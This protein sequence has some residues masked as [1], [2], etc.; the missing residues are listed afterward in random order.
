MQGV[1]D[2]VRQI[3]ER[4]D[5]RRGRNGFKA[6][7][8]CKDSSHLRADIRHSEKQKPAAVSRHAIRLQARLQA[9]RVDRIDSLGGGVMG[10]DSETGLPLPAGVA[11]GAVKVDTQI[12]GVG[13]GQVCRH[14]Q[15]AALTP[16]VYG[17][18]ERVGRISRAPRLSAKAEEASVVRGFPALVADPEFAADIGVEVPVEAERNAVA[19]VF[20]QDV[21]SGLG[22]RPPVGDAEL[23]NVV[24]SGILVEA[25]R[26]HGVGFGHRPGLV[27]RRQPV[28]FRLSDQVAVQAIDDG[29]SHAFLRAAE[30]GVELRSGEL[31]S[32]E[33]GDV[34][35]R[36]VEAGVIGM[37]VARP[38]P[39]ATGVEAA[40][41]RATPLVVAAVVGRVVVEIQFGA[42]VIPAGDDVDHPVHGR[43]A[44]KQY[45]DA[46]H[47]RQWNG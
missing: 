24:K 43:G 28:V 21:I 12:Q 11:D 38:D 1:D 33:Q 44:V 6:D 46:F 13:V 30:A 9:L 42:L 32:L 47:E 5:R 40:R 41:N 35:V 16:Y 45:L 20:R 29:E 39:G 8:E 15:I 10:G 14:R 26:Q 4:I 31:R 23:G 18:V 19:A 27:L 34:T 7:S 17:P 3:A 25:H 37:G 22:F 36:A 2:V